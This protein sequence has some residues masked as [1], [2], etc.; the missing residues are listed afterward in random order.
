M[1]TLILL[2]ILFF[3]F[4]SCTP[5]TNLSED[6]KKMVETE[7]LQFM[8]S[9]IVAFNSVSAEN[10]FNYFLHT[11]EFV[12]ATQ[13]RLIVNPNAL[14]DTMKVHL[15]VMEKQETKN[16]MD[17]IFV[18]TNDAAVISTSKI[19]TVTFKN[20]NQFTMPYALTMLLVKRDG[21]WKIAHYHN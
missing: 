19:V 18:I 14:L 15:A 12:A 13:G 8:D 17:K 3:I 16:E 6:D 20:G 21:E 1:K 5:K 9:L 10:V 4:F 7:V 2:F 11:D